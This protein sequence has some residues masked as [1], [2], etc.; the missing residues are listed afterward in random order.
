MGSLAPAFERKK[1][2]NVLVTGFGV[3]CPRENDTKSVE[4]G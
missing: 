3:R 1:E 4:L 2:I